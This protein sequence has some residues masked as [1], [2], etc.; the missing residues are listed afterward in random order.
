[1]SRC[2][3]LVLA[4]LLLGGAR[5]EAQGAYTTAQA[6]RGGKV[7]VESCSMCHDAEADWTGGKF[8]ARWD[9]KS[10]R[11]LFHDVRQTMPEDFPAS[12]SRQ[13]YADVL[14]Y[15]FQLNGMPAGSA[16]LRSDDPSLAGVLFRGKK[17]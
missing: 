11:A 6:T 4:V 12:L 1:M 13:Q 8:V 10:A 15:I 9:G 2:W 17:K 14:A 3:M 7:F 16:E 5:A